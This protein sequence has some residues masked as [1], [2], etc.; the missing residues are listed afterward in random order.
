[1][2]DDASH[3][4]RSARGNEVTT[5]RPRT[6]RSKDHT[7]SEGRR[8]SEPPTCGPSNVERGTAATGFGAWLRR[9]LRCE[10]DEQCRLIQRGRIW[11]KRLGKWA[12]LFTVG[13]TLFFSD[14]IAAM[15]DQIQGY[16]AA[17][18]T[19]AYRWTAGWFVDVPQGGASLIA[20]WKFVD[21]VQ[22]LFFAGLLVWTILW[23]YADCRVSSSRLINFR[24]IAIASAVTN[25]II[26]VGLRVLAGATGV[27]L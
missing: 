11:T 10:T 17:T 12:M 6:R 1:M 13:L 3:I 14:L 23:T 2:S 8:R 5:I 27:P 16:E 26:Y 7:D 25:L 4:E 19:F 24:R 9:L 22:F 21:F 20:I 18:T 15:I